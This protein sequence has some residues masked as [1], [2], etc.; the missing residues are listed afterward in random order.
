MKRR[1]HH[2]EALPA[3]KPKNTPIFEPEVDSISNLQNIDVALTMTSKPPLFGSETKKKKKKKAPK[4][5]P[6]NEFK[7][8]ELLPVRDDLGDTMQGTHGFFR[9]N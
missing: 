3:I 6:L 7:D 9:N 4:A 8:E 2:L 1:P 5:A